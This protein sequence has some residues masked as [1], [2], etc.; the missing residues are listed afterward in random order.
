MVFYSVAYGRTD[1]WFLGTNLCLVQTN[2]RNIVCSVPDNHNKE[3][4][5]IRCVTLI[6]GFPV[7]IK[8]K[9]MLNFSLLSLIKELLK[10]DFVA[11]KCWMSE[12]P[13]SHNLFTG[14]RYCIHVDDCWLIRVVSAEGWAVVIS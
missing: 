4:I 6:L 1:W 3:R 5:T 11:K 14:G 2:P 13:V 10:K 8:V 12:L 7:H 9:F